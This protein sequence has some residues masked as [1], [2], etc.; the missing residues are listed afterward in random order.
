MESTLAVQQ[1]I[2]QLIR[3]DQ[4]DVDTILAAPEQQDE[5]VWKYEHL[6]QFC[7]ELNKITVRLQD[8][9]NP[10]VCTQMTATEQWIFLCAAHKNPKE[11]RLAILLKMI[12]YN[13]VIFQSSTN[14]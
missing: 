8:E 9:C 7:L 14:K 12:E 3:K 6:R 2:Q 13:A 5:G 4:S 10:Q 1:F 11:V